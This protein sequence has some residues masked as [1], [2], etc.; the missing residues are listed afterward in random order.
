MNHSKECHKTDMVQHYELDRPHGESLLEYCCNVHNS[1]G[2][3]SYSLGF[4]RKFGLIDKVMLQYPDQK[5]YFLGIF[6][7]FGQPDSLILKN[8]LRFMAI[9]I[10]I[11][12][13]I[14]EEPEELEFSGGD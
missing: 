5:Y 3:E 7:S 13:K 2:V 12:N 4:M 9:T 8:Q 11:M 10:H 1:I 6:C 14:R